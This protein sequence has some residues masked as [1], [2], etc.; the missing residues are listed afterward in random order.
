MVACELCGW[1]VGG[2]PH[3]RQ[4]TRVDAGAPALVRTRVRAAAGDFT[5]RTA[6]AEPFCLQDS[7]LIA[8][9]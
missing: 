1:A 5:A 8:V 4:G 6:L 3:G 2:S 7:Q 9:R